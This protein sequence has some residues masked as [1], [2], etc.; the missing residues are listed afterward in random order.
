MAKSSASP[1]WGPSFIQ[2]VTGIKSKEPPYRGE[3]S[4]SSFGKT[5]F[6]VHWNVKYTWKQPVM[7]PLSIISSSSPAD[8]LVARESAIKLPNRPDLCMR[9]VSFTIITPQRRT[10]YLVIIYWFPFCLTSHIRI[11]KEKLATILLTLAALELI[12]Y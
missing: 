6:P 12:D 1:R 11:L 4:R 9:L 8:F 3:T 5:A 2:S 7:S 10:G